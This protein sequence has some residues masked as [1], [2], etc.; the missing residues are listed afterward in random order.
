MSQAKTASV[1][2]L[3]GLSYNNSALRR[4]II[5]LYDVE[6]HSIT[7]ARCKAEPLAALTMFACTCYF[8]TAFGF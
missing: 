1:Y 2:S 5:E 3:L 4:S 6:L 8:E 7:A